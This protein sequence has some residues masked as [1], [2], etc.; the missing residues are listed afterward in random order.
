MG[1]LSTKHKLLN[2]F[3]I[4]QKYKSNLF[5][6]EEQKWIQKTTSTT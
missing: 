1:F 4:V 5:L 2:H 6:E 3:I